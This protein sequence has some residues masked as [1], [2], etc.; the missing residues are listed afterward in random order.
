MIK[1]KLL[2]SRNT[3]ELYAFRGFNSI[4]YRFGRRVKVCRIEHAF[5][6]FYRRLSPDYF[7]DLSHFS[8]PEGAK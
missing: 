7:E 4:A 6:P 8:I 5:G 1:P 3:G 2:I